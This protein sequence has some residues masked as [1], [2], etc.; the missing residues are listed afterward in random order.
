LRLA[1]E[2]RGMENKTITHT[3]QK[4]REAR[5]GVPKT[6]MELS[7]EQARIRQKIR[8]ALKCG[9]MTV[10]ELHTATGLPSQE[11]LWYLMAWKKYGHI[12]E[13]EACEDYYKYALGK[14]ERK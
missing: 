12:V 10:P 6:L 4:A 11:I 3:A 7:R 8:A 14:E 1:M 13:G 9:P 5:G 2:M